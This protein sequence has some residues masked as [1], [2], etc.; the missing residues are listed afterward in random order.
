MPELAILQGNVSPHFLSHFPKCWG[1]QCFSSLGHEQHKAPS[2][3]KQPWSQFCLVWKTQNSAPINDREAVQHLCTVQALPAIVSTICSAQCSET[4]SPKQPFTLHFT[5]LG[6]TLLNHDWE[7]SHTVKIL[8]YSVINELI[9]NGLFSHL[10]NLSSRKWG[11]QQS[12]CHGW[13]SLVPR[14]RD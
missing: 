13:A 5:L 14:P 8:P 1:T 9:Y 6:G 12:S 3:L 11:H 10:Q 2:L 7:L 4:P